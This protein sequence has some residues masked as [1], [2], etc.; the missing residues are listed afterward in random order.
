MVSKKTDTIFPTTGENSHLPASKRA[1]KEQLPPNMLGKITCLR[2]ENKPN[3]WKCGI[4]AEGECC[5]LHTH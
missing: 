1:V 5:K 3:M 4:R 2:V